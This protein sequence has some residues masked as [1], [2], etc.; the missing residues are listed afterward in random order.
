MAHDC[1]ARPPPLPEPTRA[2][3]S[4][5]LDS[6]NGEIKVFDFTTKGVLQAAVSS[7]EYWRLSDASGRPS[8]LIGWWPENSVTF[9]DNHNKEIESPLKGKE[10]VAQDILKKVY[11]Y[12]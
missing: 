9:I 8:G 4:G 11:T 12:F 7:G 5:G 1:L 6:V 10:D 2:P 3:M